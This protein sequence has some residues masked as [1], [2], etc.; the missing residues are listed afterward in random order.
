VA[1]AGR[2]LPAAPEAG[3]RVSDWAATPCSAWNRRSLRRLGPIRAPATFLVTG[4][5]LREGRSMGG[6]TATHAGAIRNPDALC[7]GRA[8]RWVEGSHPSDGIADRGS[9]ADEPMFHVERRCSYGRSR[10]SEPPPEQRS[11]RTGPAQAGLGRAFCWLALPRHPFVPGKDGQAVLATS[12]R[13]G[14][15]RIAD[16]FSTSSSARTSSASLQSDRSSSRTVLPWS[17]DE[18]VTAH[19][20]SV[21][22]VPLAARDGRTG[23]P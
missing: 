5:M 13:Y 6:R 10:V 9:A 11:A 12:A 14:P 18:P 4:A 2:G 19:R 16:R 7:S 23:R 3:D 17:I 21:R 22:R 1:L 20:R 15:L 8:G